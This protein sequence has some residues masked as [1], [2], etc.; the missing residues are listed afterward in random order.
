M[1][2]AGF[3]VLR[4]AGQNIFVNAPFVLADVDR[5]VCVVDIRGNWKSAKDRMCD[6]KSVFQISMRSLERLYQP[7]TLVLTTCL[8]W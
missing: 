3:E 5:V 6:L 2:K 4:L 1:F 7:N 8:R